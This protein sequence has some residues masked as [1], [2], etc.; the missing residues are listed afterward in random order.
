ME[1]MHNFDL[2]MQSWDRCLWYGWKKTNK[3][4]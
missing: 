1:N 2:K 4:V 3:P